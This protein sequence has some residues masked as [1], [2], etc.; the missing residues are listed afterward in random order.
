MAAAPPDP[1]RGLSGVERAWQEFKDWLSLTLPRQWSEL[2]GLLALLG[3]GTGGGGGGTGGGG[4]GGGVNVRERD[5]V[6][7][8]E[9]VAAWPLAYSQGVTIAAFPVGLLGTRNPYVVAMALLG[10][11]HH[12][13]GYSSRLLPWGV[14][15][16]PRISDRIWYPGLPGLV[17][18]P[19]DWVSV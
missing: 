6:T 4:G 17:G 16:E 12:T 5:Q 1:Y 19:E 3:S 11:V 18:V 15:F 2:A 8:L 14:I 7:A 9:Y 10:W 13:N